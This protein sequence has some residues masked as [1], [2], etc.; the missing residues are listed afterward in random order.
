[1]ALQIDP[2]KY[3]RQ[4]QGI[5]K[6]KSAKDLNLSHT[7]G[8]GTLWWVTG[9]GKTFAACTIA[10]KMLERNEATNFIIVVPSSE[11]EKQWK[12]EIKSFVNE[13]YH[14][15][16][17][18]FTIHKLMELMLE[19]KILNCTLLIADEV[20]EYYTDDRLNLFNQSFIYTKYCLGLTA[21]FE[22]SKGR[23]EQIKHILPV[24]DIIDEEEAE[25]E[26]YVSKSIE[27]NIGLELTE[28]E[29]E[30]YNSYTTIMNNNLSKFGH[31]GLD[32]VS[33]CLS[34]N[35]E[36]GENN[37][38]MCIKYASS[39][40]WRKDLD[41][42]SEEH[43]K[44]ISMWSPKIIM[45][46]AKNVMDA[47]RERKNV[48][49]SA[50]NKL[51]VAR[52]VVIKFN[53]L[54]TIC[55]SQSTAFADTLGVL[56]N[57]HYREENPASSPVCVVYHSKLSTILMEADPQTG[58]Q[59]RKGKTVLKREAIE[60]IRTGKARIISTASSLDRGFDVRDIRMAVT[61]SGTQN[62]TQYLQ[63]K[64][65]AIRVDK[66][67]DV[68]LIINCYSKNTVDEFWLRKRQSK[69][70]SIVYWINDINSINYNPQRQDTFNL[71]EL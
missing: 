41:I 28:K 26:G 63:R 16:F 29:R 27:Y 2:K 56:I 22:D 25:R 40:G 46:Y 33:K 60:A 12:I 7:N 58:K 45:G 54:K 1:M 6:W 14:L 5:N 36:T 31:H 47:V 61:T 53:E 67:D 42:N 18:V 48:I 24:V 39:K 59:K 34:G 44:I 13:K 11:L 49:Y 30:N 35:K 69:S 57:N 50:R 20:H 3:E 8:W 9:V 38:T 55:F 64:G 65:R 19:G 37:L 32:L 23:E 21:T 71:K 43:R 15:H 52:D 66:E 62:P 4:L 17:Q 10:N 68:V 70:K 51:I